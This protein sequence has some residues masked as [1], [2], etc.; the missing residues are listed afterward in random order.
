MDLSARLPAPA[1]PTS[2][3]D[4]K[5]VRASVTRH[6][7][8][9]PVTFTQAGADVDRAPREEHRTVP[10]LADN[11]DAVIG[12]DT[13]RDTHHAEIAHP[14]GA[15]IATCF[16]A[17]TSAGYAQLLRWAR[18]HAPGP[19]L[20]FCIEGTRSYGAGLARAATAAGLTV[21]ECE[22]PARKARRGKGKSDPIDA[23]LAV[24][25][26]LQLDAGKLPTPRADGDREALRILLS[27]R[28]ELTTTAT[29]QANRLRAL[30]RDGD[31]TDRDLARARL[32]GTVL[33]RLARRHPPRGASRAQAVRHGEIR[34]LTLALRD[35]AQALKLNRAELAAIVDDLAPGLTSHPGIGPVSAAQAIV[36]FSHP[37]RCRH[38]AAFARLAGT[39]PVQASSGQITRHR[40]N[41]GGDRALNRAIHVIA[42]T[43]IRTDPAT[44]AYLTRR[45]A[46]GKSDREIRRCLKRYIARQLYRTLTTAMTPAPAATTQPTT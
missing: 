22:Q 35:A 31:D 32:S 33:A 11:V 29:A 26:A 6:R 34:R 30:L 21:I 36:S 37:G 14:S 8:A 41:R 25:T 39:S 43:R 9:T 20:V 28:Q 5:H 46:Q 4:Q 17:S 24:L 19:R 12:V 15:T 16:I 42:V 27:A 45:R 10:M 38:D 3:L 23:H 2:W 18:E 1:W 13:H 40:L 7:Y 44:Q